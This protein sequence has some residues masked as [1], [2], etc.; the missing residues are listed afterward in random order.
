MLT[1]RVSRDH[2]RRVLRGALSLA[3]M[4]VALAAL[5]AV[6][7]GLPL[8]PGD[9]VY[10]K[11]GTDQL[12][13]AR[14]NG[15]DVGWLASGSA[16]RWS[17]DAL[18]VAFVN[19][20]SEEIKVIDAAT[21]ATFGLGTGS[22]F[23]RGVYCWDAAGTSIYHRV[24]I[25]GGAT[26]PECWWKV[27]A[28]S[29]GS[30]GVTRLLPSEPFD[31]AEYMC[32]LPDGQ[33]VAALHRY[34]F[35][36]P[37]PGEYEREYSPWELVLTDTSGRIT[38]RAPIGGYGFVKVVQPKG[39]RDGSRIVFSAA[40]GGAYSSV[41]AWNL[42][43]NTVT[44]LHEGGRDY[45]Y[46]PCFTPDGASVIWGQRGSGGEFGPDVWKMRADGN[47]PYR[48]L[49]GGYAADARPMDVFTRV[50]GC[51][52]YAT[53][54]QVSKHFAPSVAACVVSY[55]GNFPDAL[56][57]GPLARAYG[58]P[59]LLTQTGAVPS[60]VLAELKR[61]A[62][63]QVFVTGSTIV[64]SDGALAQLRALPSHPVVT[65]LAGADRYGT[66]AAIADQ[67]KA[68]R[69]PVS[70]VV[71]VTGADF[72]DALAVAPLA[73]AKGWPILLT[74][75]TALPSSTAACLSRLGAPSTLVVGTTADVSEGVKA[76]LKAA[77]R[78][79]SADPY[80]TSALVLD[81]AKTLGVTP[82]HV[83]LAVGT[84]YPDGLTAGPYLARDNGLLLLTGTFA[85]PDS[86]RTRLAANRTLVRRVDV[87]GSP[88]AVSDTVI[89]QARSALR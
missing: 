56:A 15:T 23:A 67:V 63:K 66:A 44:A 30:D 80:V 17:P 60:A 49:V 89:G 28:K 76:G 11:A 62:P 25:S 1:R 71:V 18:H 27:P 35:I 78:I 87:F 42:C 68:R 85:L 82:T 64:V 39:S 57:A 79:G 52:R 34:K 29:G 81:Y 32:A 6:A 58:G 26:V 22:V 31:Y 88:A 8:Q 36:E 21:G 55:G 19:A 5:P 65:R 47:S 20:G 43:S 9:L 7:F 3:L 2:P 53:A 16:P 73:A 4:V 38:K 83:G 59:V 70:K 61:L 12:R 24:D 14:A 33:L 74:R 10:M 37:R 72:P 86:V 41:Y 45:N 48:L 75:A 77:T 50:A 13:L 69:G 51:D 84:K 40:A 54:V 46:Y